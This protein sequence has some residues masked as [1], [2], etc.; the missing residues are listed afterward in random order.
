MNI[1]VMSDSHLYQLTP[2]FEALCER[3]CRD[4]DLVIH[5]GDVVSASVLDYLKQYP[6]EAVAG[7]MD[8]LSIRQQLPAKKIIRLGAYRVGLIH[9]W[10]SA[11]DLPA[12]LMHEF[13]DVDAV[14]FGHTHEGVQYQ[15]NGILWFNP[16]SVSMGRGGAPRSI[17][18]LSAGASLRGEII[19][20]EE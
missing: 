11:A 9:G 13:N 4:A 10:G 12:R 18:L 8:S 16:G 1:V 3:Y 6:L 20:L 19:T 15:C 2:A 7:N 5:L 14:L 17:G